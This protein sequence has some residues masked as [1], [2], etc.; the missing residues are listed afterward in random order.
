MALLLAGPAGRLQKPTARRAHGD[1]THLPE[2][3]PPEQ[4]PT[5]RL[6]E[7]R[8]GKHMDGHG[9][10]STGGTW[11]TTNPAGGPTPPVHELKRGEHTD[12]RSLRR[13]GKSV[14]EPRGRQAHGWPRR[15]L[16]R[17]HPVAHQPRR[18]TRHR[19]GVEPPSARVYK[20]TACS[21]SETTQS[22]ARPR[23]SAMNRST[24]RMAATTT[25]SYRRRWPTSA[26][27]ATLD[28]ATPDQRYPPRLRRSGAVHLENVVGATRIAA[29]GRR[30]VGACL[31]RCR[32]D[33]H[34][35]ADWCALRGAVTRPPHSQE[36]MLA[37]Q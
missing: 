3:N 12:G 20:H 28:F 19:L 9:T 8:L 27:L 22:E 25:R 4:N 29:A 30:S 31:R 7:P 35:S 16:A 15:T 23:S 10:R 6:P 17:S 26:S 2:P 36:P 14:L 21:G 32:R 34:W 11:R 33:R 13:T 24:T 18:R 37:V 5:P 1:R